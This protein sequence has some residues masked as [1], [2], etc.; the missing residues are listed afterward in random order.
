MC[1]PYALEAACFLDC[2]LAVGG[3]EAG[4]PAEGPTVALRRPCTYFV[5]MW[6]AL[7]RVVVCTSLGEGC[8]ETFCRACNTLMWG[9][10]GVKRC[11]N[12]CAHFSRGIRSC[13]CSVKTCRFFAFCPLGPPTTS[14]VEEE[15]LP[16]WFMQA[17]IGG[18]CAVVVAL[19]I[20]GQLGGGIGEDHMRT[21]HQHRACMQ[22][23]SP[24]CGA[25]VR[26]ESVRGQ[27]WA[28]SCPVVDGKTGPATSESK[29]G[30]F[31]NVARSLRELCARLWALGVCASHR[32][33]SE[34][35]EAAR[36]ARPR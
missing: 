17:V 20:S 9:R 28:A 5:V 23:A 11:W 14:G 35:L 34:A 22:S 30:D 31:V 21:S 16:P 29:H 15:G 36:G 18:S 27:G 24:D 25:K 12:E 4:T 7:E 2:E 19:L 32:A 10:F 8:G 6:S 13:L 1:S 26:V 33:C 3:G